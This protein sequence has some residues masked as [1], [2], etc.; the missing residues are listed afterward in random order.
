[1]A[2][3]D[4]GSIFYGTSLCFYDVHHIDA[5]LFRHL[6]LSSHG[7]E[8]LLVD[9]A[10]IVASDSTG[11][12]IGSPTQLDIDESQITAMRRDCS[13]RGAHHCE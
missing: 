4:I 8:D 7:F 13:A 5:I 12:T 10:L 9:V 6:A 3:F 1:M 11:E 2:L